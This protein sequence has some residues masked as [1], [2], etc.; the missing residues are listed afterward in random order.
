VSGDEGRTA[1]EIE[2]LNDA[3][4]YWAPTAVAAEGAQILVAGSF[5]AS[6]TSRP[7]RC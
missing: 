5:G 7:P 6:A 3:P 1:R 4:G 2:L